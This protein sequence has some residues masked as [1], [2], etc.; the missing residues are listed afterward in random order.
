LELGEEEHRTITVTGHGRG[1][2]LV[3]LLATRLPKK[4]P[5]EATASKTP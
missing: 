3:D 5:G 1:A 4:E 2:E